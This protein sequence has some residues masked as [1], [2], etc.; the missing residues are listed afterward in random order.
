MDSKLDYPKEFWDVKG[1][2]VAQKISTL[3]N[4][5]RVL[6]IDNARLR[7]KVEMHTSFSNG[8]TK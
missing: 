1:N 3:L 8:D 4:R 2:S 6:E 5:I 7:A